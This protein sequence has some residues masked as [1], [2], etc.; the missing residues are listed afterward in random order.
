MLVVVVALLSW[1][2]LG[3]GEP[4]NCRHG[5]WFGYTPLTGKII[6]V[7]ER[8]RCPNLS[9]GCVMLPSPRRDGLSRVHTAS[10]GAGRTAVLSDG[11]NQMSCIDGSACSA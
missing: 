4:S 10:C 7:G 2:I 11:K 5:G 3:P 6:T 9:S 8:P 1:A